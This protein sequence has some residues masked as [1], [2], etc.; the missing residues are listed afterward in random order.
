[1]VTLLYAYR[2]TTEDERLLDRWVDAQP[3]PVIRHRDSDAFRPALAAVLAEVRSGAAR[4]LAVCRI[5]DLGFAV[6]QLAVLLGELAEAGT[7]LVSVSDPIKP[8]DP[9]ARRLMVFLAEAA[10]AGR[11]LQAE[12]QADGF[13]R[14]RAAGK[15]WGGRRVGARIRLT[16]EKQQRIEEM[17]AAGAV[18]G[19][20]A[21]A[22]R[23]S[24]R[25]IYRVLNA[26][27]ERD[28]SRFR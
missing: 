3:G 6:P 2:P 21:T 27:G 24:V 25:T 19:K 9:D 18:A 20:I 1:M 22:V 14:A 26:K 11:R 5:A 17:H 16:P 8:M 7:E 28:A 23:L 15:R 12:R 10:A 13:A 4:R